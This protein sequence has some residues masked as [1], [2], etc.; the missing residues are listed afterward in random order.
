MPFGMDNK[1]L[2]DHWYIK[3]SIWGSTQKRVERFEVSLHRAHRTNAKQTT[4]HND[5]KIDKR[6]QIG[7]NRAAP[8][9]Q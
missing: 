7:L 5:L 3:K 9:G 1:S 8:K 4:H 2:R 6:S